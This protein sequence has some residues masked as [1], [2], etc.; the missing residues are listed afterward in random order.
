MPQPLQEKKRYP[1]RDILNVPLNEL[2]AGVQ[3]AGLADVLRAIERSAGSNKCTWM[4]M[5]E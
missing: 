3:A 1:P 5:F 2:S 4:E